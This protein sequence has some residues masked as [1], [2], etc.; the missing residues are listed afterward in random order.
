MT[1]YTSIR[2]ILKDVPRPEV[3][4]EA[5]RR[6]V[7]G[8]GLEKERGR[9]ELRGLINFY[10]T[11]PARAPVVELCQRILHGQDSTRVPV[12][13]KPDDAEGATV[14][15]GRVAEGPGEEGEDHSR[16]R[17]EPEESGEADHRED[18]ASDPDARAVSGPHQHPVESE[19][20]T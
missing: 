6:Y 13:R 17:R 3:I 1:R 2:D 8:K 5:I 15:V 18:A 14:G 4:V 20:S 9:S 16:R 7:R 11:M 12:L 10:K 19:R